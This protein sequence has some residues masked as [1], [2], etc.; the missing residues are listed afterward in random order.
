M[1]STPSAVDFVYLLHR[2]GSLSKQK[3]P[4]AEQSSIH[5]NHVL[6]LLIKKPTNKHLER[7]ALCGIPIGEWNAASVVD[8]LER[9]T[10]V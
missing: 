3:H 4:C 7:F 5:R 1:T 6:A 9:I 8:G 10:L 2:K